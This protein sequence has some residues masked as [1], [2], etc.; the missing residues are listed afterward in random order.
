MITADRLNSVKEY[1]FSTKLRE[2]RGL[3]AQGRPIINM[4][5]GSPDLAPSPQVL[6][7]LRDSIIEAGAHQYQSYQGL[8]KLR[9]AIAD[10][11]HQKFDV[12][13]DPNTDILPLMGSKEGIMHISMAFLNNGDEALIPN[14]GYPTYAAVTSLV[15][16]VPIQYNLSEKNGWF[17]DLDELATK[18]LSKV[19]LMWVSYPHMPTG[20]TATVEQLKMLVDFAKK[21]Q[22]LLVNDNPYSFV[23]SSNPTSI[24]S[25]DGA[26]ECTLELN[27]LS[28]TFN[29]AGWRVGMVLGNAEHINAVLKVK[30]NMDSGMFYGIQKGAIAALQSGPE[31]FEALDTVYTKRR[32]LMFRLVDKLGCS[33]DEN[34]VGMFVWSK[35]PAGS[36][37]SEQFIDEILYSR[38][39][40]IAPGTIFGSNGEGYIRFSLCV[41]EEKIKE[42]IQRF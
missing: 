21:N 28:K 34:A 20:A 37:P 41:K 4:G 16:A 42:A 10:F 13:V 6:E 33:Y 11:Y 17:P 2:V 15:G 9:E 36:P 27:S 40:F 24:L 31:W 1:Y 3:I 29:M 39:I 14:P 12:N 18:D 38:D 5:I 23:L 25:I 30:S 32:E 19:K 8:P 35:L 22:I 7:T 26:K